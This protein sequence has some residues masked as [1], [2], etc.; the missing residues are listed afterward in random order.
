MKTPPFRWLWLLLPLL[1]TFQAARISAAPGD[2]HWS[3][4]F[5]WPGTTTL[6]HTIVSHNSRLY[7]GGEGTSTNTIARI[8]DGVQWSDIGVFS[9][10]YPTV[11][12]LA[13]V[14]NTLYAAGFFT[15]VNGAA[16]KGLARWDGASWNAVGMTGN[17]YALL[18]DGNDLYVGGSF[19][20]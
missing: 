3:P 14:G 13:W 9:G 10:D 2:E 4:Q 19:T 12:D 16:I 11:Y 7:I 17:A 15:N 8:W 18:A 5:G 20:N 6:T 1:L